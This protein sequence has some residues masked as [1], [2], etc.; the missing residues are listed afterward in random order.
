MFTLYLVS[1]VNPGKIS[2]HVAS[3]FMTW[4][5]FSHVRKTRSISNDWGQICR[6]QNFGCSNMIKQPVH[7]LTSIMTKILG[8]SVFVLTENIRQKVSGA[9][10]SFI[11]GF[12]YYFFKYISVVEVHIVFILISSYRTV[13]YMQ[14]SFFLLF[15]WEKKK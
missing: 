11:V 5:Q 15:S 3:K 6:K 10:S 12:I 13:I 4:L 8:K 2:K 1:S 9:Y 7:N 14:N